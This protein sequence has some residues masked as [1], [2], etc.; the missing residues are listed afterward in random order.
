VGRFVDPCS[1]D[2][3]ELDGALNLAHS[4]ERWSNR[5]LDRY[6]ITVHDGAITVHLDRVITGTPRGE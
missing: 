3:W 4:T 1:G 5:N 2:E 6:A